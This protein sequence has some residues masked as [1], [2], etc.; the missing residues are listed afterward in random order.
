MTAIS[1]FQFGRVQS[2]RGK[3]VNKK[4]IGVVLF[5]ISIPIWYLNLISSGL[6]DFQEA[7]E[8]R[9]ASGI[10]IYLTGFQQWT[11]D[12]VSLLCDGLLVSIGVGLLFY[13]VKRLPIYVG[14]LFGLL[15]RYALILGFLLYA[16][17]REPT[18]LSDFAKL[19]D[20]RVEIVLLLQFF[21]T[22]CFSYLGAVYGKAADY[23][24]PLDRDLCYLGRVP[25]KIWLLLLIAC[26]PVVEFLSRLTIVQIYDVTEKV[27]SMKFWKD[28]FSLSNLFSDDSARGVAGLVGHLVFIC[29]VWGIAA[30]LFSFGL[31][32]I[33]D[34]QVKHRWLKICGVFA[35]LPAV[36]TIV[37]LLRN[38]TWF[39]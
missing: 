20:L 28:T 38:R 29:L 37:P 31:N 21:S 39:F 34:K 4:L 32:A 3:T 26:R 24:D 23:F 8:Q 16:L 33:R 13:F 17:V 1:G 25:K 7:L 10:P 22:L 11:F 15:S 36:I 30:T 27:T 2:E 14:L 6:T 9:S 12:V 5:S 35:F 19:H 18:P